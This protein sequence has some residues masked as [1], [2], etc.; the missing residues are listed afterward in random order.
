MIGTIIVEGLEIEC[1][2][3]IHPHER[4][5]VQTILVDCE[6]DRDF[7]AAAAGDDVT[8]TVDYVEVA[9][10]LTDLAVERQYQ[11]IETFAEDAA[12][13]ILERFQ[14]QRVALKVAKPAA[15]P[16]AKWSAVRVERFK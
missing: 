9:D 15:I 2:V 13:V 6:L 16:K 3:G 10:L 11:L 1:I 5:E 12:A 8:M 4:I 14:A 7:A